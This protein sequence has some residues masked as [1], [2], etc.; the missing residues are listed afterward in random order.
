[1]PDPD[2]FYTAAVVYRYMLV[3]RRGGCLLA[4]VSCFPAEMY[5]GDMCG[6]YVYV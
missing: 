6:C 1:M 2:D 5:K 4:S 3:S